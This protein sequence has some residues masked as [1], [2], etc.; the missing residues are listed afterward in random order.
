MS[1]PSFLVE[2]EQG[3]PEVV[4]VCDHASSVIP[5]E[6]GDLGLPASARGSHIAYDLG[7]LSVASRLAERLDA[8]LVASGHSRLVIDCNRPPAVASSIPEVTGGVTVPGNVGLDAAERELRRQRSFEPYHAA[9]RAALDARCDARQGRG[10]VLLS[11]HSFTPELLGVAR[12]WHVALLYGRDARLAH[13]VRD[14]LRADASL[15]VGDNEPYRVTDESDYTVPV[16]G[17]RRGLLHTA[18]ELR[19]DGLATEES[20]RAWGDRLFEALRAIDLDAL[21]RQRDRRAGSTP[22]RARGMSAPCRSAC[23]SSASGTSAAR[24]PPRR[25][26]ASAR[27]ARA[28][29]AS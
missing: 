1:A 23:A 8:T 5:D 22:P 7:A 12:P 29:R 13:A 19:Q 4:V 9:V 27:R 17:E 24:R 14:V 15:T 10:P 3:R 2:R 25:C 6:L 21:L 18:F 28:C 11:V 26:S 20:A 16:H